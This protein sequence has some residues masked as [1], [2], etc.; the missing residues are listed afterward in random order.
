MCVSIY[1]PK[2]FAFIFHNF[3][4]EHFVIL[5]LRVLLCIRECLYMYVCMLI[6]PSQKFCFTYILRY[7][8]ILRR[9]ADND[10]PFCVHDLLNLPHF[11]REGKWNIVPWYNIWQN[12]QRIYYSMSYKLQS[13]RGQNF[14]VSNPDINPLCRFD[15]NSDLDSAI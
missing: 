9:T 4:I 2:S 8:L 14:L 15:E 12:W 6:I 11:F 7:L 5:Y 13:I 1:V 10:I 3:V